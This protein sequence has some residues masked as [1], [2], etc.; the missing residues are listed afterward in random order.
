MMLHSH[1]SLLPEEDALDDLDDEDDE[2]DPTV[3]GDLWFRARQPGGWKG[4]R[5]LKIDHAADA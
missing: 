4:R 5:I 2:S 1:A 3:P